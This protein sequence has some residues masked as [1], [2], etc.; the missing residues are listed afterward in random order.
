MQF[1]TTALTLL[2]TNLAAL[3]PTTSAGRI[4]SRADHVATTVNGLGA[5]QK[6][7]ATTCDTT[8]TATTGSAAPVATV[9]A[10]TAADCQAQCD[11]NAQCQSFA[12]GTVDDGA[13]TQCLLYSVAAA[14]IPPSQDDGAD[15]KAYDK[16]CTGVSDTAPTTTADTTTG[17]D[18]SGSDSNTGSS[19]S[20]SNTGSDSNTGSNTGTDSNTG[21]NSNAGSGTTTGAGSGGQP[22]R[23]F[24][25]PYRVAKL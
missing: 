1:T 14:Q 18:N 8:P 4:P 2:L 25:R 23:R 13:S 12:F 22:A 21:T 3:A 15:L 9:S 6:R 7:A 16:S 24:A 10:A 11:G 19:D 5:F 17:A 20:G